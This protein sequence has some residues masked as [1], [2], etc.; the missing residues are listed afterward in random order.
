LDVVKNNETRRRGVQDKKK[1]KVKGQRIEIWW[2]NCGC[3]CGCSMGMIHDMILNASKL[4][5][6]FL[7]G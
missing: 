6:L 5:F 4:I 7:H 1:A 2:D 3:G